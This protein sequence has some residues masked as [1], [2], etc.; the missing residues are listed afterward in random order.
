M[1]TRRQLQ[2]ARNFF[3]R[4]SS[5]DHHPTISSWDRPVKRRPRD[6]STAT[7]VYFEHIMI[8]ASNK[9]E[10]LFES[11]LSTQPLSIHNEWH[12]IGRSTWLDGIR[13]SSSRR[14]SVNWFG[15]RRSMEFWVIYHRRQVHQAYRIEMTPPIP[16]WRR[17][18]TDNYVIV[19]ALL[20]G[21]PGSNQTSDLVIV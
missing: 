1:V 11:T 4:E 21:H 12:S 5:R 17:L 15:G 10:F 8:E 9:S 16:C 14:R 3:P 6:L 7:L 13:T 18:T 2:E 20:A 19:A